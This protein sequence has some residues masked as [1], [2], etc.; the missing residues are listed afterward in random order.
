MAVNHEHYG[1]VS[2]YSDILERGFMTW[3]EHVRRRECRPTT[4]VSSNYGRVVQLRACKED[5]NRIDQPDSR[6]EPLIVQF[7]SKD[8][9]HANK[10]GKSP[11]LP[12]PRHQG[13]EASARRGFGSEEGT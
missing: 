13:S 7:P 1:I 9:Q 5:H 4:G 3:M 8:T 10:G 2:V 6:T 12:W 11:T